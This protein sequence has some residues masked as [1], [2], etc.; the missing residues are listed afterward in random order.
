MRVYKKM[1][2]IYTRLLQLRTTYFNLFLLRIQNFESL[3][4]T[5]YLFCMHEHDVL[6][7]GQDVSSGMKRTRRSVCSVR[8]H[9]LSHAV[10]N[11][12]SSTETVSFS[13]VNSDPAAWDLQ[14][15]KYLILFNYLISGLGF[16][17]DKTY[18]CQDSGKTGKNH[19]KNW[20]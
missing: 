19:S 20:Q 8:E 17:H 6:C 5:I 18:Y 10:L 15:A 13:S 3:H 1:T 7:V 12:G 11:N 9:I 14:F 2:D 16:C 4:N